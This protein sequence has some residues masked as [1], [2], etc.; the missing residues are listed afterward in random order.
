MTTPGNLVL[1]ID[2]FFFLHTL[3]GLN[4]QAIKKSNCHAIIAINTMKQA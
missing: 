4:C 2:N 1:K 3:T